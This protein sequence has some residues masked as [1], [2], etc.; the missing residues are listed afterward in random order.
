MDRGKTWTTISPDLT[1]GALKPPTGP[2]V[3]GPVNS[4]LFSVA[5]SPVERGLIWTGSTDGALQLT[6]DGGVQWTNVTANLP[7]IPAL[8]TISSIEPSR[9]TAEVAYATIDCHRVNDRSPYVIKTGDYGK[10]WTSIAS[11]LPR[12]VVSYARVIREDPVRKSLLYLG[13]ESGLYLSFDDGANWLPFHNRLP[14]VP[15]SW[16]TVQEDFN[17]L[18]VST[19]GRGFWIMDDITPLQKLSP[20][21]LASAAVSVRAA[22]YV[23]FAAQTAENGARHR[24]R[25]RSSVEYRPESASR[26]SHQLLFKG[27]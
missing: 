4:T 3:D 22:A 24:D 10:T 18:V 2:W 15:V 25:V 9:H 1:A 21:A 14:R 7:G 23:F 17:D 16:I 19:F 26:R 20:A 12:S 5:E 27:R 8:C 13:T 6:R 11:T